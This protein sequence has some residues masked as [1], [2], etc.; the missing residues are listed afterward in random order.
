[1][2]FGYYFESRKMNTDMEEV[3]SKYLDLGND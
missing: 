3:K 2:K 1:M